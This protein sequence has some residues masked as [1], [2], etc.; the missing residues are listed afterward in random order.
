L[1]VERFM[2]SS[3]FGSTVIEHQPQA[4]T[5]GPKICPENCL[6]ELEMRTTANGATHDLRKR[7]WSPAI[8]WTPV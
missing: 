1:D 8:I 7:D 6:F 3:A 2:L 4:A 5:G